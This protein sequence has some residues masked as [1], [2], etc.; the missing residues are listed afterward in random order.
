MPDDRAPDRATGL[1]RADGTPVT[2][3]PATPLAFLW[4]AVR[5][6]PWSYLALLLL[7]TTQAGCGILLPWALGEVVR[8]VTGAG[9][10]ADAFARIDGPFAWFVALS[11]GEVVASR[12]SGTL[13]LWMFPRQ[14]QAIAQAMSAWLQ[15]HSHRYLGDNFAGALA[16]RIGETSLGVNQT[17]GLMLFDFWPVSVVFGVSI[18]LL[19]RA[20]AGLALFVSLWIAGF[21]LA[22]FWLARRCQPYSIAA[23]AARSETNGR[24]V[25][26]VGNL[27]SSRLFAR[28]GHERM[29]LRD[30]YRRELKAIGTANRYAEGV[31][32]FQFLAAAALKIGMLW[33]AI[34]LWREGAIGVAEFVT[35][36]G[37]ALLIITEAR[38]LSRRFLELFEYSGNVANGVNTIARPHEIVDA[39]GARHVVVE[40]GAIELREVVFGYGHRAGDGAPTTKSRGAGTDANAGKTAARGGDDGAPLVFD[41]LSLRIAPGE[42]VGLVGASGSGKSTLVN[43]VLRLYD[44]QSGAILIDGHDLRDFT[45]DSLHAQIGL[46]P[47]DPSLFH[48]SLR[49][50]IRYGRLDASDAE[51]EAAA[52]Q[53][54]AHDF[55]AAMKEGY[56]SMVGERGVKLSGGQRQRIAIARVVLKNAPVL[57]LDEATSALDSLT[58]QAIQRTLDTVMRGKTVIVVAHRL[59]TIAHLDRIVVFEH[60]RVVEDGP[61]EALLARRG[62]YW[63]LWSRQAGGFL[64]DETGES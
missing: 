46:I 6:R 47:Q 9:S 31:R 1:A 58:E 30:Q 64:G 15:G 40:R 27:T 52:R 12:A 7:E 59:S 5:V 63:R 26:A 57:I 21:V 35:V 29:L 49:D 28:F 44:P 13:F 32:W 14:R 10:A 56:D 8:T 25:D 16:H 38:N 37:L 18:V 48:R 62:A 60:G 34:R 22:S 42:R 2:P 53:A 55:I 24:I 33:Y 19:H 43:L 50:N 45:Q 4:A 41:R 51:V 39:P 3:L 36:T 17:L 54:Q 61:H 20:N 11:L 23:A